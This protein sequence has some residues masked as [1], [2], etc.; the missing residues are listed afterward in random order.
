MESEKV[1]PKLHM[2]FEKKILDQKDHFQS[3]NCVSKPFILLSFTLLM[4][5]TTVIELYLPTSKVI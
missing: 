4:F 1:R 3:K 2:C 5:K